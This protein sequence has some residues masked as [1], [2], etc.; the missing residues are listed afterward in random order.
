MIFYGNFPMK[1]FILGVSSSILVIGGLLYVNI[2]RLP[3]TQ[4]IE[5]RW[6]AEA[7]DDRY[8]VGFYDN[9]FI[10]TIVSTGPSSVIDDQAVTQIKIEL[11]KNIKGELPTSISLY[12]AGGYKH[13]LLYVEDE[14]P[15]MTVGDT[16]LLAGTP[17]DDR[18]IVTSFPGAH[19]LLDDGQSG[20][21]P[22]L[23]NLMTN[24]RVQAVV[25]AIPEQIL[26]SQR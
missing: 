13:G 25:K 6:A 4:H 24:E 8:L 16:Y 21:L 23:S 3:I 14:T 2:I 1:K 12:Q 22:N 19:V 15:I 11:L 20:T 17:V 18:L 9:F 7:Y 5:N 10:G 26:R